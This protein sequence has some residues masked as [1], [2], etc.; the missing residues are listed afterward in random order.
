[1]TPRLLLIACVSF[2]LPDGAAAPYPTSVRGAR[3]RHLRSDDVAE[4]EH[5]EVPDL[6]AHA[7]NHSYFPSLVSVLGPKEISDVTDPKGPI[8]VYARVGFLLSILI[9]VAFAGCYR[10]TKTWPSID[11]ELGQGMSH[12]VWSSGPFDCFENI[13]VCF[14][15]CCCPALR[16]A[17]TM[18]MQGFLGFWPAM[19]VWT[20][21]NLLSFAGLGF[22]WLLAIGGVTY[23]RQKM[24][25][26][27]NMEGQ[28]EICSYCGD[29]C[30][31]SCCT[32]CAV[33]QE[34]RH[35]EFAAKVDHPC[36]KDQRPPEPQCTEESQAPLL[37]QMN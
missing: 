30:F 19:G 37:A 6:T 12:R 27:F 32:L 9:S 16:W 14:W 7:F 20:V 13:P 21:L 1:M 23:Y 22:V 8:Q 33:A 35:V 17:D 25:R 15:A 36:V 4:N 24:R 11:R 34:A 5:A 10:A 18:D 26:S 29:C 3:D 31:Y 2:L 28:G